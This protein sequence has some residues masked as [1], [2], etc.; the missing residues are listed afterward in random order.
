MISNHNKNS[1]SFRIIE[2]KKFQH[3]QQIPVSLSNQQIPILSVRSN[4]AVP[5]HSN[6]EYSN[7]H[8][9]QQ[10]QQYYQQQYSQQQSQQIKHNNTRVRNLSD[11]DSS[12][13]PG[14]HFNLF[15]FFQ[16][17]AFTILGLFD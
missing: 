7:H 9:Q 1:S 16:K 17:K 13:I 5:T 15:F 14:K 10:Q 8:Q 12:Y 11:T 2:P 4:S 3:A 6:F